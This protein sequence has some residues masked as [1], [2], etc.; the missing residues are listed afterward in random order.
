MKNEISYGKSEPEV[1]SGLVNIWRIMD[2]SIDRGMN[3]T[4]TILPGGLNVCLL[5]PINQSL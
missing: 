4:Q 5:P 2:R 3:S 1:L